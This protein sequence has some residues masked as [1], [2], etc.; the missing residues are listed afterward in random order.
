MSRSDRVRLTL[1]IVLIVQLWPWRYLT[2]DGLALLWSAG[3]IILTAVVGK[4]ATTL[5]VL[6]L[7][8]A[9]LQSLTASVTTA[10]AISLDYR[11]QA[12]LDPDTLIDAFS[13]AVSSPAPLSPSLG[14]M[15]IVMAAATA[16]AVIGDLAL[17]VQR[18][19][20]LAPIIVFA[21]YIVVGITLPTPAPFSEFALAAGSLTLLLVVSGAL[22]TFSR[23]VRRLLIA[24]L[25]TGL[26]LAITW[27]IVEQLP[28]LTA[29]LPRAPV[30]MNDPSLDL[31]RNLVR[32][33]DDVILT[34]TTDVDEPV[35]LKQ[36][37]LTRLTSQG[38][39]LQNV[40]LSAGRLPAP[41]GFEGSGTVRTTR[42]ESGQFSSEW[43][44][45]PYAPRQIEAEGEWGHTVD[46]LDVLSLAD[47][48]RVTA[49]RG[50][51]Y[52]VESLDT[53]P[54]AADIAAAETSLS[55]GREVL[56]EVPAE[57]SP[58]IQELANQITADSP[59]AGAAAL[60]IE[61]YLR[62]DRYTYDLEVRADGDS[63]ETLSDFLFF[64]RSG[65]CEQ[66][67]GSMTVLARLAGIPARIAVGFTP[68]TQRDDGTWELTARNMHTWPELWLEGYGWVGFE[69]TPPAGAAIGTGNPSDVDN[70][71]DSETPGTAEPQPA[72]PTPTPTPTPTA[73]DVPA[74]S[75]QS[76]NGILGWLPN[77]LLIL[78][79]GFLLLWAAPRAARILRRRIRLRGTG[80]ARSDALALWAEVQES[81]TDA[82]HAWP[83]GSPRRAARQLTSQV[84]RE[85]AAALDR[86]ALAAERA[87]FDDPAT[88]PPH[89]F[90]ADARTIITFL[91][92][93]P[94]GSGLS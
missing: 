41:P 69:P 16:I 74:E 35:R 67:A 82:G 6:P 84:N 23:T 58:D 45:V 3:I 50:L 28:T 85:T 71:S 2:S 34:Y 88:P 4:L 64:S 77:L 93:H 72:D 70:S 29:P 52:T 66:F 47:R 55:N 7:I 89:A 25:V 8:T 22:G 54:S 32:G 30:Q 65:Y 19:L 62:S 86:L 12:T 79:A 80:D 94:E 87:S 59:T 31:K 13:R 9:I 14:G 44:P 57:L 73:D 37:T 90:P 39:G 17:V 27:F 42:V 43:L 38:F 1:V 33:T 20:W 5:R 11:W 91:K 81:V 76:N 56:T 61:A 60:A 63:L 46:T 15:L 18:Q 10:L 51:T 36:A 68:G 24:A 75:D 21:P 53:T 92:G 40:R 83:K 78:A 49:T 48:G 26:S